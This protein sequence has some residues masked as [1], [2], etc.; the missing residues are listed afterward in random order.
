MK[1]AILSMLAAAPAGAILA[2]VGGE[3]ALTAILATVLGG[4][5]LLGLI[6]LWITLQSKRDAAEREERAKDRAADR[7]ERTSMLDRLDRIAESNATQTT[8]LVNAIEQQTGEVR[9]LTDEV[10]KLRSDQRAGMA[11]RLADVPVGDRPEWLKATEVGS[12]PNGTRG[13]SIG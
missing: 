8:R 7:E 3:D 1:L 6:R 5:G 9:G 2:S 12:K 10:R 4:G 13:G 11:C